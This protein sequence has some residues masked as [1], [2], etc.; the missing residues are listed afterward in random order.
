MDLIYIAG[1]VIFTALCV[2]LVAG[3]ERL[4]DRVRGGRP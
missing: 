3:F 4:H 1:V 2:A